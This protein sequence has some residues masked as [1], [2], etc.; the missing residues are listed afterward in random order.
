MDAR[1]LVY[2]QPAPAGPAVAAELGKAADYAVRR[3]AVTPTSP[4][5][6]PPTQAIRRSTSPG[7][8]M[9][10]AISCC[11]SSFRPATT[12]RSGSSGTRLPELD[13]RSEALATRALVPRR[14]AARAQLRPTRPRHD[15]R[16]R[17][18][19]NVIST[20]ACERS[21]CSRH[22]AVSCHGHAVRSPPRDRVLWTAGIVIGASLPHCLKL[23]IWIPRCSSPASRGALPPRFAGWPLPPRSAAAAARVRR[24]FAACLQTVPAPSTDVEAGSALLVVMVA[25]KFLGVANQRDQLV[26]IIIAVFL[27]VREPVDGA[28]PGRRQLFVRDGLDHDGGSA[29]ARPARPVAAERRHCKARRGRLLLQALPIMVV[30]FRAV[31]A[32]AGAAMGN[33]RQH[34]QRDERFVRLD[35]PR[36]HHRTSGSRTRSRFASSSTRA[37]PTADKLYWR[38]P[39]LSNFDGRNVDARRGNAARRSPD[40]IEHLGSE[41]ST[42]AS[43]SSRTAATGYSRWTCRSVGPA[44]AT[45]RWD[46]DYQLGLFYGGPRWHG[47]IIARRRTPITPLASRS[48]RT[49]GQLSPLC[50]TA[51]ARARA[52]SSQAGSTDRPSAADHRARHGLSARATVFLHAD[53]AAA[54]RRSPSTSSC[55]RL[56]KASASTTRRRSRS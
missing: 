10:G 15:R 53:A 41:P 38:G 34:E 12:N 45:S 49:A 44:V 28:Q 21:R 31:P 30:L 51:A 20:S 33:S 27:D 54:R 18:R 2:P 17:Q 6:A 50:R 3:L 40:T 42:T 4:A 47:S 16:A 52:R 1:C 9:R 19:L 23:A 35:E 22:A 32:A 8:R 24:V 25:L 5:C 48:A 13:A 14:R 46:S 36:R 29:A 11:S 7:K 37:A 56:A 39:V 55:S 43:C 26:L